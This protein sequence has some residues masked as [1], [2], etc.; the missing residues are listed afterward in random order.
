MKRI[1]TIVSVCLVFFSAV[2]VLAANENQLPSKF[3]YAKEWVVLNLFTWKYESK[4]TVLDRYATERVGNIETTSRNG[5]DGEIQELVDR[6]LRINGKE[7]NLIQTK[8]ISDKKINMVMEQELE[9]QRILSTIRQ[10]TKSEDVKNKM[11]ET[12]ERVV[13]NIKTALKNNK[14]D[15]DINEFQNNIVASW[16]DPKGELNQNQER[17]TRVYTTG[18]TE[19]GTIDD[20]VIIDG[21][22][23]KI[24]KD[25]GGNLKIEYAPGTGPSS[26]TTE[27]GLRIWKIVQSDGTTI[28]SYQAA[29]R[30]VI[31]QSTGVS[32]NVVV[33]TV[34]DGTNTTSSEANVVAGNNS[35]ASGV[36]VV[37][38]KPII[39]TGQAGMESDDSVSDPSQATR[40]EINSSNGANLINGTNSG[41]QNV[42]QATPV[43][44]Q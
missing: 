14:N 30:V 40:N 41:G 10:E 19:N 3:T 24:S 12:Q 32:G 7:N 33:N 16:R 29:G 23:A 39:K 5:S 36:T 9:R 38:G 34:A 2:P 18:T 13:N 27:S 21:G 37:G 6:Y 8:N 25:N 44:P 42:E 17:E 43:S 20:G 35:A 28:D 22:E 11:V 15:D 26:T 1:L 31:G 4:L